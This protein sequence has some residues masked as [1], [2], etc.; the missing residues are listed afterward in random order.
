MSVASQRFQDL[1]RQYRSLIP[2]RRMTSERWH[3]VN[4][5]ASLETTRLFAQIE[6]AVG[7]AHD[8]ALLDQMRDE[9]QSALAQAGAKFKR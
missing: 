3:L 2:S 4:L 8:A 6:M 7:V 5:A 9:V 1:R